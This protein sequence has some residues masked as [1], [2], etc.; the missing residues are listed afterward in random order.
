MI[1]CEARK[2]TGT[3]EVSLRLRMTREQATALRN[4]VQNPPMH[5]P[6]VRTET[7]FNDR[8]AVRRAVFD[9]LCEVT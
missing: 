5:T 4:L 7:E 9:S 1:Q 2:I 6:E 8:E 3:N